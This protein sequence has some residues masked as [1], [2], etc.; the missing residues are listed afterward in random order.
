MAEPR[1]AARLAAVPLAPLAVEAKP[2]ADGFSLSA[3]GTFSKGGFSISSAG[4]S[5]RP[6]GTVTEQLPTMTYDQLEILHTLGT[7]AS[8]VVKVA[9]HIPT[10]KLIALKVRARAPTALRHAPRAVVRPALAARS[11]CARSPRALAAPRRCST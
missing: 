8:S 1:R 10:N 7:G 11:P 3:T 9:R 2:R 5:A 4:I 6:L